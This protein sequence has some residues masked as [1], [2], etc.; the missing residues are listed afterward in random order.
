[1]ERK[2]IQGQPAA[3]SRCCVPPAQ[4]TL[5]ALWRS[6]DVDSRG[7]ISRGE[8]GGEAT[9]HASPWPHP[10]GAPR[11]PRVQLVCHWCTEQVIQPRRVSGGWQGLAQRRARP[12]AL[13][14]AG[15]TPTRPAPLSQASFAAARA[16][17]RGGRASPSRWPA[18]RMPCPLHDTALLPLQLLYYCYHHYYHYNT[19]TTKLLPLLDYDC[20]HH[21]ITTAGH[22]C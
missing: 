4:P 18:H 14:G 7:S 11:S 1:M 15:L 19:T 12:P 3:D 2:R 21:C 16:P 9:L 6:I 17:P 5:E 10:E 22:A 13:R 20:T 8:F